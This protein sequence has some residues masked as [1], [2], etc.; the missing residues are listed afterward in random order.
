MSSEIEALRD[1]QVDSA[2]PLLQSEATRVSGQECVLPPYG[3][4]IAAV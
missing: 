1:H 4:L 3:V 2:M